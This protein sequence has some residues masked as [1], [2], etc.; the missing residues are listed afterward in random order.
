MDGGD[1]VKIDCEKGGEDFC[2]TILAGSLGESSRTLRL[3]YKNAEFSEY[4]SPDMLIEELIKQEEMF[5]ENCSK[6]V[7]A[8]RGRTLK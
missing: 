6:S 7:D 8:K 5:K 1:S 2:V 3:R 4:I